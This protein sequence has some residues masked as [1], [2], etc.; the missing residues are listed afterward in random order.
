MNGSE[1]NPT[2]FLIENGVLLVHFAGADN[3][4]PYYK[5]FP[6]NL[7]AARRD[8][9]DLC[10][11]TIGPLEKRCSWGHVGLIVNPNSLKSIKGVAPYDFGSSRQS[12]LSIEVPV[13]YQLVNRETLLASIK[14]RGDMNEWV[15][16]GYKVA[17]VF[18]TEDVAW[19][20][21]PWQQTL[22][23]PLPRRF[24]GLPIVTTFNDKFVQLARKLPP[25]VV[26]VSDVYACSSIKR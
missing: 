3:A 13:E 10:C 15:V 6:R 26:A 14:E 25:E 20:A 23:D 2:E 8:G 22:I 18:V 16:S 21:Q 24:P 1:I 12:D 4:E 9:F 5:R 7:Q 11:S 19:G 17:G